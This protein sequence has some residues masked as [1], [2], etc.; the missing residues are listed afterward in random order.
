MAEVL[1]VAASVVLRRHQNQARAGLRGRGL[2]GCAATSLQDA[3]DR[4]VSRDHTNSDRS[5]D[6][7]AE[8]ERHE[9]RNHSNH[10]V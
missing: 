9:E 5:H 7:D 6:G 1:L 4:D 8:Y 10:P 2:R 3:K